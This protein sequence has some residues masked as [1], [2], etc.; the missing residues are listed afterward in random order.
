M[1]HTYLLPNLPRA[2]TYSLTYA[3]GCTHLCT[4]ARVPTYAHQGCRRLPGPQ[5]RRLPYLLSALPARAPATRDDGRTRHRAQL[6]CAHAWS[7]MH[8]HMHMHTASCTC[9]CTCIP[10]HSSGALTLFPTLNPLAL[11]L[12]PN[13]NLG[14][15]SPIFRRI[16]APANGAAAEAGGSAGPRVPPITTI[17]I[18][19]ISGRDLEGAS[20]TSRGLTLTLTLT[21][22]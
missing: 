4:Y 7:S 10:T 14:A 5:G 9:I 8:M 13:P 1:V 6:P 2:L 20:S 16:L 19:R 3:R 18:S 11:A 17:E 12:Y 15:G 21:L 22:P